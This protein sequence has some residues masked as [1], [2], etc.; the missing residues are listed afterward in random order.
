MA[1][2][3]RAV[4]SGDDCVGVVPC[5]GWMV[6]SMALSVTCSLRAQGRVR[7]LLTVVVLF[8]AGR[9]DELHT[10]R[11]RWQLDWQ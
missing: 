11:R 5:G 6:G 8:L 3:I 9:H 10:G 7:I 2:F 1:S 4:F